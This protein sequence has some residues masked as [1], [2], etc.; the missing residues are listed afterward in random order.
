VAGANSANSI[1][2]ILQSQGD[3]TAAARLAQGSIWGNAGNRIAALYSPNKSAGATM[4]D[5]TYDD[6][7]AQWGG[8]TG[9]R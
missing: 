7:G 6:T 2:G 9:Q 5:P 1:S 3:A 8:W 4:W